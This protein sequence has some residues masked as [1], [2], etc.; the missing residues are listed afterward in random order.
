MLFPFTDIS[1]TLTHRVDGNWRCDYLQIYAITKL[2]LKSQ[3]NIGWDCSLCVWKKL[4]HCILYSH[5]NILWNRNNLSCAIYF[6][7]ISQH[8]PH[9]NWMYTIL[10]SNWE[11][12]DWLSHWSTEWCCWYF[13]WT[14][15]RTNVAELL[16]YAHKIDVNSVFSSRPLSLPLFFLCFHFFFLPSSCVSS[17]IHA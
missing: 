11:C 14:T 8:H 15:Y 4:F 7:C 2:I 5:W 3:L 16:T 1:T 6:R 12:F 10:N 17:C 13:F 9:Q